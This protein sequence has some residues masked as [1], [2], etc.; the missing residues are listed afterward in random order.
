MNAGIVCEWEGPWRRA[1]GHLD[2]TS[3]RAVMDSAPPPLTCSDSW[4]KT[5]NGHPELGEGEGPTLDNGS[6]SGS[7]RREEG[8][9]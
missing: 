6:H 9:G 1:P 5:L 3:P 2:I 4:L 8:R 7:G